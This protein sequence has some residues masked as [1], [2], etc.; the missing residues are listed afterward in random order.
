[1]TE[2]VNLAMLTLIN[3]HKQSVIKAILANN[4]Y[5]S[6]YQNYS[7]ELLLKIKH[8]LHWNKTDVTFNTYILCCLNMWHSTKYASQPSTCL[9]ETTLSIKTL[10]ITKFS[11]MTCSIVIHKMWQ[12][13][14]I[15]LSTMAERCYAGCH[16]CWLSLMLSFTYTPLCRVSLCC[17]SF[18][19]KPFTINIGTIGNLTL[20]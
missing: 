4:R 10:S 3:C 17:V 16:L 5:L 20:P 1:M 2:S 18:A 8:S 19:Q 12:L 14:I 6:V 11:I 15:T 13:S 7:V 9:S